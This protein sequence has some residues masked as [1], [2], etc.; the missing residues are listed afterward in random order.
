[1]SLKP[2]RYEGIITPITLFVIFS[3]IIILLIAFIP[4]PFNLPVP[5]LAPVF[6]LI[7]MKITKRSK[8]NA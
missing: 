7:I 8:G 6:T 1:M 4:F 5:L 2:V 3:I